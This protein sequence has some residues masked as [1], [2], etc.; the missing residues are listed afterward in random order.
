MTSPWRCGSPR[1]P[2][3]GGCLTHGDQ[4]QADYI[5]LRNGLVTRGAPRL[6]TER[7]CGVTESRVWPALTLPP[8]LTCEYVRSWMVRPVTIGHPQMVIHGSW[9]RSVILDGLGYQRLLVTQRPVRLR[10]PRA[11]LPRVAPSL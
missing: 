10:S 11:R 2:G 4:P 3:D 1:S 8:P 9:S 7:G 5:E 6:G